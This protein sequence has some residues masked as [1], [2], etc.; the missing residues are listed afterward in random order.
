MTGYRTDLS[1]LGLQGLDEVASPREARPHF[2]AQLRAV[3]FP[4][5]FVVGTPMLD[6]VGTTPFMV[7]VLGQRPPLVWRA[8]ELAKASYYLRYSNALLRTP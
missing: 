2:G 4:N 1:Y 5:M 7:S 6:T 3:N 8:I